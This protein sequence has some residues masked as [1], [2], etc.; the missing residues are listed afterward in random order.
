MQRALNTQ[1]LEDA[2]GGE[3]TTAPDSEDLPLGY[4]DISVWGKKYKV[5]LTSKKTGKKIDL[6]ISFAK[7]YD[8]TRPVTLPN[9]SVASPGIT[10]TMVAPGSAGRFVPASAVFGINSGILTTGS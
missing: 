8:N 9:I 2:N 4:R 1:A 3:L 6:N 10:A 5:R 7:E